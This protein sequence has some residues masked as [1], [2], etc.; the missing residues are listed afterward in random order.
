MYSTYRD[1]RRGD[2]VMVPGLTGKH[3]IVYVAKRLR[4]EGH[5]PQHRITLN[6][7]SFDDVCKRTVNPKEHAVQIGH[8]TSQDRGRAA[9][10]TDI[11]KVGYLDFERET[12]VVYTPR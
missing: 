8:H 6:L 11:R 1:I 9:H 4:M 2:I 7:V 12:N 5:T 3:V 10:I